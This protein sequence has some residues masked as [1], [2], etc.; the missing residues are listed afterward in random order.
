MHSRAAYAILYF[1]LRDDIYAYTRDKS[2]RKRT[3][4]MS[5]HGDVRF[6]EHAFRC[7]RVMHSSACTANVNLHRRW[8]KTRECKSSLVGLTKLRVSVY[9]L[10]LI[11]SLHSR[12]FPFAS[13]P[14]RIPFGDPSVVVRRGWN[15][16]LKTADFS[17]RVALSR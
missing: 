10:V 12:L 11:M 8:Q 7:I 17:K 16:F 3:R 15:C 1:L 2:M 13:A 9:I 6:S 4:D 14:W 5:R